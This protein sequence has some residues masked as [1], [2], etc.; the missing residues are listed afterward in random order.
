M[1]QH[2]TLVPPFLDSIVAVGS[3][4]TRLII[5]LRV[6]EEGHYSAVTLLNLYYSKLRCAAKPRVMNNH[7][8]YS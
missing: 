4:A 1:H 2:Y 5:T 6:K 8:G 7:E 3:M